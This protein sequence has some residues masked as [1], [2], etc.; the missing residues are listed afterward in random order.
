MFVFRFALVQTQTETRWMDRQR[1][2]TKKDKSL[3]R[4]LDTYFEK[5]RF[6]RL[7]KDG[8]A[9]RWAGG[10]MNKRKRNLV[11]GVLFLGLLIYSVVDQH[12]PRW[13]PK[14]EI[15]VKNE[16]GQQ[17]PSIVIDA[18]GESVTFGPLEPG[19]VV[20]RKIKRRRPE[21]GFYP[22]QHGALAD[23]T[24]IKPARV[25]GAD[26]Q[27]FVKLEYIVHPDGTIGGQVGVA[28]D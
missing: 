12:W 20:T 13:F 28:T 9:Q 24:I 6:A 8:Q 19:K 7:S 4:R 3:T 22:N 14:T 17:V 15:V 10:K 1:V 27:A 16:S 18:P 21:S 5:P 25:R 11:L 2:W 23:G 26:M